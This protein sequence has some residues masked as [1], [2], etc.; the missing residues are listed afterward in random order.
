MKNVLIAGSIIMLYTT[1]ANAQSESVA[2]KDEKEIKHEVRKADRE[3]GKENKTASYQ[4]I[5]AF[6]RDFTEAKNVNWRVSSL[7]DEATFDNKGA[8]M[9]AYYDRENELVGTT[10]EKNFDDMPV[11]AQS[12]IHSHYADY[13]VD[14]VIL[15]DDNENNDTDMEL[16]GTPFEDEDNYFIFLKKDNKSIILKADMDGGVSFFKQL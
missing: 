14:D 13:N 15:F 6:L 5:Q 12:Y 9:T 2:G 10:A 16:Y 4:S 11:K 3:L 1:T 8:I 7:F